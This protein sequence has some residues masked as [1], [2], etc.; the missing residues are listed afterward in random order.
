M[1]RG[2]ME[3]NYREK[4][5]LITGATG[6]IGSNLVKKLFEEHAKIIVLGRSKT[7]IENVFIS[8][9][10]NKNFS[11][12]IANITRGVPEHIKYVDYIFHAAS[13]ISSADI[14]GN[15]IDII[16]ANLI[17]LR[18]CLEFLRKQKEQC[19]VSGRLVVFSSATVYG[20]NT[21]MDR[22]VKEEE[23]DIAEPLHYAASP[24]S[25]SKRMIEV[26][27]RAYG[28]QFGTDSVIARIGYVYGYTKICPDTAF[29]QFLDNAVSGKDLV[30][31]NA[32]MARR[33][34]IYV[35]DVVNA[36]LLL[37]LKGK[38]GECYNVASCG[39][40]DN[41]KAIDEIASLIAASANLQ[42]KQSVKTV[43]PSNAMRK[44]GMLLDNQKLKMLG[45]S[46]ETGLQEGI[47]K[48]VFKYIKRGI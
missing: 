27:A 12:E 3:K 43:L 15:P 7:K 41:F 37:G 47:D 14:N 18:N 20:N 1:M 24:Y 19:G 36:L 23:S 31:H 2:K 29:Y 28:K 6:L 44:P 5:I 42:L 21:D 17:G 48:T 32:G 10:T 9:L 46:L 8:Y 39:E 33:D 16:D 25:E 45:W 38:T 4:V 35:E 13:S 11:Y 26:L 34:N 30:F 22:K 40:K